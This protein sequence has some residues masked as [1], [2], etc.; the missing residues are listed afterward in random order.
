MRRTEFANEADNHEVNLYKEI[1]Q[2]PVRHSFIRW[3][4][5]VVCGKYDATKCSGA[6]S[7]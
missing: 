4:V 2:K 1:E 5:I 6:A 7:V 3:I